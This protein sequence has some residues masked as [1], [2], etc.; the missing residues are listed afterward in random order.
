MW[1][2]GSE[3]GRPL[4]A[5]LLYFPVVFLCA[6]VRA[7]ERVCV[8]WDT[9]LAGG[10]WPLRGAQRHSALLEA[11]EGRVLPGDHPKHMPAAKIL[12]NLLWQWAACVEG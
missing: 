10:C 4:C 2:L 6:C 8:C 5:S 11:E 9:G 3:D 1:R 12:S 7:R